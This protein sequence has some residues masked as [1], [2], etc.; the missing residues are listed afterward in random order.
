MLPYKEWTL[1]HI[2]VVPPICAICRQYV[3]H[4]GRPMRPGQRLD[5]TV[6]L[7]EYE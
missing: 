6:L 5:T 1:L 7:L 3:A 2:D 4:I